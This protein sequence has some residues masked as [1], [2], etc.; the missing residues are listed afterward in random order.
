MSPDDL[1]WSQL[2]VP[3][4]EAEDAL[5]RFDERLRSSPVREGIV[6]RTHFT[7]ACASL[8]IDGEL[9]PIEDLVLHDA[10]ADVRAPTPQLTRAQSIIQARRLIAD[11]PPGW[12]LSSEGVVRLSGGR[13]VDQIEAT[14]QETS[15]EPSPLAPLK[16]RADPSNDMI[17]L[18]EALL[19]IDTLLH[20]TSRLVDGTIG[21]G[22]TPTGNRGP[23]PTEW[24]RAAGSVAH[25]P[26]LLAAGLLWDKWESLPS[27]P[28][29]TW[30]GRQLVSDYLRQRGKAAAHLPALNV[31]LRAV[32]WERRRARDP[33]VRLLAWLEAANAWAHAGL[34]EHDRLTLAL[35]VM[36]E[37]CAS[38]RISSRL[39]DLIAFAVAR[40]L[41]TA[42][43]TAQALGITRRGAQNL[44]AELG[45]REITGR[46]RYRAWML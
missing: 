24:Q 10:S 16:T 1:P 18:D 25:L 13:R 26:P 3:L 34:R 30:F 23:A 15:Q 38:R 17:G 42:A 21:E 40:P 36:E 45:L 43:T 33:S 35:A 6:A 44:I 39:P 28:A 19:E 27:A 32:P 9:V 46:G 2:A 12:A 8:W 31:G 5:A 14:E 11:N 37:K 20:R 7:D 41:V 29:R 22:N 4:V